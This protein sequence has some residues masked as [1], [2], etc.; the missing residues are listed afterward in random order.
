MYA[1]DTTIYFT[2]EDLSCINVEKN[3]SNELNKI[4]SWLSLN[5]LSLNTDKTK[6]LTFHT[7]QKNIDQ[8]SFSINGK[9]IEKNVKFFKFLVIMFDEHLT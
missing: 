4:N 2:M 8:L 7:W 3:V 1:A 6:C 5:K 9:Q